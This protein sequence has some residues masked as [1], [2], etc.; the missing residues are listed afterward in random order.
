MKDR[1]WIGGFIAVAVFFSVIGAYVAHQET[2]Q[3]LQ[4]D[5]TVIVTGAGQ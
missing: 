2:K 5:Y 3:M 4:K 1:I